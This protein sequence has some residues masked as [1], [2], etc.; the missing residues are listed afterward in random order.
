VPAPSQQASP[1][2]A[3]SPADRSAIDSAAAA[4]LPKTSPVVA[5]DSYNARPLVSQRVD[6]NVLTFPELQRVRDKEHLRYVASQPCLLCS[7]TPSDAHHVHFAQP[8]AM[9]RKVGDDFTVPLCRKHHRDLHDSGNEVA[10]W[11]DIGT[12]PLEITRELWNDSRKNRAIFNDPNLD[13]APP[14]VRSGPGS[15]HRPP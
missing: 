5:A 1:A 7:A 12:E 6:E 9:A 8:R 15:P 2:R 13:D 4:D 10:W 3:A 14:R 11:H